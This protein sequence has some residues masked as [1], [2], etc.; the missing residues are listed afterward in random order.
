[1]WRMPPVSPTRLPVVISAA[2]AQRVIEFDCDTTTSGYSPG[3]IA[4]RAGQP[5]AVADTQFGVGG[6]RGIALLDVDDC[7]AGVSRVRPG[8][9]MIAACRAAPA[10]SPYLRG[11]RTWLWRCS[12]P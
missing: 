8:Q 4:G 9:P 10:C 7:A 5:Q 6:S 1:M 2:G 12:S 3:T 11:R